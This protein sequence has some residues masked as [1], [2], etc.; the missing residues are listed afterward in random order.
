MG[1]KSWMKTEASFSHADRLCWPRVATTEWAT[2]AA[3]AG[4]YRAT[5]SLPLGSVSANQKRFLTRN[6]CG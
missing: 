5:I 2:M 3:V 6:Q 1:V 4:S